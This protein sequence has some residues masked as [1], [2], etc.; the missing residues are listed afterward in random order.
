[1]DRW[2]GLT[3]VVLIIVRLMFVCVKLRRAD[4]ER[5]RSR[6]IIITFTCIYGVV[7]SNYFFITNKQ[8]SSPYFK[9]LRVYFV[10]LSCTSTNISGK[11][12]WM[13]ILIICI[14]VNIGLSAGTCAPCPLP[15]IIRGFKILNLRVQKIIISER[16]KNF[17]YIINFYLFYLKKL[18]NKKNWDIVVPPCT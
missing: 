16:I 14:N 13:N 12:N 10:K 5:S 7:T 2:S 3:R 1:M 6:V 8:L 17:K 4:K 9:P 15:I 18:K 11:L